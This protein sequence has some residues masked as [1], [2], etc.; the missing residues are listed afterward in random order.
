MSN[1][2]QP[3][4]SRLPVWLQS[5]DDTAEATTVEAKDTRPVF[6]DPSGHRRILVRGTATTLAAAGV[7]FMA[8]AGLLLSSQPLPAAP[9]NIEGSNSV[10]GSDGLTVAA[11]PAAAVNS[12]PGV[13]TPVQPASEQDADAA[14]WT[15]PVTSRPAGQPEVRQDTVP[16]VSAGTPPA[17]GSPADST[18]PPARV[19]PPVAGPPPATDP[20]PVADPPPAVPPAAP[21]VEEPGL[22][23]PI[24]DPLVTV[25][26]TLLGPLL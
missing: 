6:T 2:F 18:A 16:A 3:T 4:L 15:P 19:A 11:P 25:V 9:Y 13:F 12:L 17:D 20:P 23:A 10:G 5:A 24:T 21:P 14:G 8:G 22:L 26:G 7:A 1:D